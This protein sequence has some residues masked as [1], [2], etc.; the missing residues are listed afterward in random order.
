MLVQN[1]RSVPAPER[2]HDREPHPASGCS[3]GNRGAGWRWLKRRHRDIFSTAYT[4]ASALSPSAL[5]RRETL[6]CRCLAVPEHQDGS[7]R[8]CSSPP[9]PSKLQPPNSQKGAE[10]DI[11]TLLSADI[12]AL[13]LQR[14]FVHWALWNRDVGFA[15]TLDRVG[16]AGSVS[17]PYERL[18]GIGRPD[19]TGGSACPVSC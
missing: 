6:I 16:L 1:L 9:C 5:Q 14:T 4:F 17:W 19:F 11:S 2:S 3:R 13:L 15:G 7:A 10:T 12:L 8:A 18:V